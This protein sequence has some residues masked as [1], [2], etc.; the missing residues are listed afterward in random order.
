MR[1][2]SRWTR[3]ALAVAVGLTLVACGSATK[4]APS[5][6]ATP[7][8]DSPTATTSRL[9]TIRASGKVTI[10]VKKDVPLFGLADPK[11]GE[12]TGFDI[13]IA[14]GIAKRLFLGDANPRARITFVE[15][16]SKDRERLLQDGAVDLVVSTYTINDARK[17]LV[18][19]AGPYYIAGQDV[20]TKRELVDSGEITGIDDVNGRKVCSVRGSTSL[21]NLQRAAPKADVSVLRDKYSECFD[22]LRAGNVDAMTTDDVILLGLA[23]TDRRFALTGNPFR[24]EPYGVGIPK[25]DD[26]LRSLVNDALQQMYD[27]GEWSAAFQRTVGT[28]GALVPLPPAIDRY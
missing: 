8:P 26:E 22:E 11:T 18:D 14:V 23:Q 27:D 6:L 17:Q 12:L 3:S 21:L 4:S 1:R 2:H 24:T 25:G 28:A 16:L 7:V 13:E 19:F 20:L 5:T 9:Q 10:G 15:A